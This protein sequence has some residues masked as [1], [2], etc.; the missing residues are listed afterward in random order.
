MQRTSFESLDCPLA[1]SLEC[2]GEWWSILILRDSFLG[3]SR[4]DDFRS[5][6][7]IAPNML[8]RRLRTLTDKGLLERRQYNDRPPRFEYVLTERGRDF[9]PVL[10]SLGT[11]GRRHVAQDT[12]VRIADRRS[13]R[14]LDPVVVDRA[15]GAPI[16]ADIA[17]FIRRTAHQDAGSETAGRRTT[18]RERRKVREH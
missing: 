6:L 18:A 2:I 14:L 13:G 7:G 17:G 5:R 1:R 11:W 9:F 4:F 8:A 16:T 10:A 3:A 15:T 12:T